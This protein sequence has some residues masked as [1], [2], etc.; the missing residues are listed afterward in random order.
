[1]GLFDRWCD[2]SDHLFGRDQMSEVD[3]AIAHNEARGDPVPDDWYALSDQ[4]V[5]TFDWREED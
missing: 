4:G 5:P 1:M 3:R 2:F